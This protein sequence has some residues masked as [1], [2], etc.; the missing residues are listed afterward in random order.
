[1]A[2]PN[3]HPI[4]IDL[5]CCAGG[6]ARGYSDAGFDVLGVDKDAQ[7][8]YPY[9]F[10]QG[11]ALKVLDTLLR[12]FGVE[13]V[14][15]DGRRRII[16]LADV[17]AIHASPPCHDH[18]TLS[19][20]TG[21][22]GTGELLHETRMLLKLAS[23][24]FGKPWVIENVE[25]AEMH[26]W[27]V[28]L[29][30][31]S[32]FGLFTSTRERGIV[33]LRRHRLFESSIRLSPPDGHRSCTTGKRVIGVYGHGDGGGR[34]WKGSFTDRKAVMGIDWMNR[35]ELAQAIPPAYTEHIGRQLIAG[36]SGWKTA[37]APK[38]IS[39]ESR[40]LP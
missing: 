31:G 16:T 5:F 10:H 35:R 19:R 32:Q 26:G 17:A 37:T 18:S 6:A 29:L 39:S 2:I 7:P 27:H 22:D 1:M 20:I 21:N 13:F 12:G 23:R 9:W 25:G 15:P 14:H 30:C 38:E 24:W 8:R 11:D 40:P 34:G 3:A 4:L 28:L 36:L 33:W